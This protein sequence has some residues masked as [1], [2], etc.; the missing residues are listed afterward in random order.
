MYQK[1]TTFREN[2]ICESA[3]TISS[4]NKFASPD[5]FSTYFHLLIS[6][7]STNKQNKKKKT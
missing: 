5:D 4:S 3:D 7:H 2:T 1:L 6:L